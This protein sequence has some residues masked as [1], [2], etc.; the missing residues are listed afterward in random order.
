MKLKGISPIVFLARVYGLEASSR[1]SNTLDRVRAAV[2]GG[3]IEQDTCETLSEAYRFL[4]RVRLRVQ[5]LA[6]SEG[7][8]TVQ[9]GVALGPVVDGAEPPA[10]R[11]PGDRGL[12][13]AGGVPLPD[14]PLLTGVARVRSR[15]PR[16]RPC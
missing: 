5:I 12:A 15:A 16:L 2:A 11:V 8:P 7:R 13:G 10:R 6:I 3:L 14:R 1:T 4:L 9:H